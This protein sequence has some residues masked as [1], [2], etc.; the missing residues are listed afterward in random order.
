MDLVTRTKYPEEK[1]KKDFRSELLAQSK[2]KIKKASPDI[3]NF[4]V[5]SA[6]HDKGTDAGRGATCIRIIKARSFP[7]ICRK[8]EGTFENMSLSKKTFEDFTQKKFNTLL[9]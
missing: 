6:G 5:V 1:L 2:T 7:T 3:F 8:N 4:Y 9:A